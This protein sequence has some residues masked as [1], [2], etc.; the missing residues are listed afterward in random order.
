MRELVSHIGIPGRIFR[1]SIA[2][3]ERAA[4]NA[5]LSAAAVR[6]QSTERRAPST[7]AWGVGE[8]AR[9]LGTGESGRGWPESRAVA[10]LLRL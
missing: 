7:E 6:H 2:E 5:F 10:V 1:G 3:T 4:P 9:V 8:P